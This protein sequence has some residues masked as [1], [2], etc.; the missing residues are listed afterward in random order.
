MCVCVCVLVPCSHGSFNKN[1][2][3]SYLFITSCHESRNLTGQITVDVKCVKLII[4]II[5]YKKFI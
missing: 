2:V 3:R 4:I 5:I 1:G